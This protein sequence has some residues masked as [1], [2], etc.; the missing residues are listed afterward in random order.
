MFFRGQPG[1]M[2]VLQL[3]LPHLVEDEVAAMSFMISG[4]SG[5]GK[6][7]LALLCCNFLCANQEFGLYVPDQKTG[8]VTIDSSLKVHFVDEVHKLAMPEYFY[9][10]IDSGR[11]I[12]FFATN[13]AGDLPEALVNRCK[14][15]I[16]EPYK[17][18]DLIE[19][20]REHIRHPL[21]QSF[22]DEFLLEI[23]NAGVENPRIIIS[24]CEDLSLYMKRNG[25]PENVK[26]VLEE[27]FGI[28]NGVNADGE[29]YL[30][31]LQE[32]GGRASLNTLAAGMH[33]NRNMLLYKIEPTLLHLKKIHISSKGRELLC[34]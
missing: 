9:P 34:T 19:I 25:L 4:P 15:L 18:K 28:K 14:P 5:W 23:V 33:V 26:Y 30:Q 20:A 1:I 16:F 29:R 21:R 12:F 2:R 27:V 3:W 32:L 6:T 31:L 24:I 8:L 10:F 17:S 13:E 7:R 22:T 11:Y